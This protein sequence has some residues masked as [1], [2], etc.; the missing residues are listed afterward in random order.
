MR[1]PHPPVLTKQRHPDSGRLEGYSDATWAAAQRE[2]AARAINS[3]M[4]RDHDARAQL[5]ASG[6]VASVLALLDDEVGFRPTRGALGAC[7]RRLVQRLLGCTLAEA[8][9]EV[10]LRWSADAWEFVLKAC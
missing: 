6:G 4:Q 10:G 9:A 5:I 1:G 2:V 7:S 3:L 8:P